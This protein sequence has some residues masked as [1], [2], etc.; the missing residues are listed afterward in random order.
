[1]IARDAPA[2]LLITFTIGSVPAGQTV[3]VDA[4]ADLNGKSV[5]DADVRL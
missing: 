4:Y 1:M 2:S 5:G 3:V